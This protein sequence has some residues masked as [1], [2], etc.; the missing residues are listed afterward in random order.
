MSGKYALIIGNTEYIDSGLAQ[1]TAPGRKSQKIL[2]A[3]SK[4]QEICAFDDVTIL[5]N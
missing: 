3:F 4:I 5:L 1:F 2:H